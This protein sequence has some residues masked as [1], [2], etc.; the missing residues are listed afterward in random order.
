[1]HVFLVNSNN[2]NMRFLLAMIMIPPPPNHI[3]VKKSTNRFGALQVKKSFPA[4][5]RIA[6][7]KLERTLG[8]SNKVRDLEL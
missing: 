7:K 1:M 6:K 2:L 3:P 5:I 8:K 4:Y